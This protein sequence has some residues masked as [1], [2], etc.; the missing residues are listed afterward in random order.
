MYVESN[1]GKAFFYSVLVYMALVAGCLFG[2]L[3]LPYT[4]KQVNQ[5]GIEVNFGNSDKGMGTDYAST[6]NPSVSPRNSHHTVTDAVKEARPS[7]KTAART[8]EV[9]TQNNEEAASVPVNKKDIHFTKTNAPQ[10]SRP[11]RVNNNALYKGAAAATGNG[12]GDGD[13]DQPGNQGKANGSVLSHSYTGTGT[14]GGGIALNLE[15]R[16]FIARPSL[17]DDGQSE[18]RIAVQITVSRDGNIISAK[19]GGRG[20]TIQSASLWKKCEE[21]ARQAKLNSISDGPEIQS[22]I[23]IFSFKLQ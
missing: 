7:T 14:G 19:A 11:Q 1:N 21:A 12:G 15:G 20:T 13:S 23:V 6:E 2:Y 5:G 10:A 22:G 18:G 9:L 4:Q 8:T 17:S 16:S 3:T